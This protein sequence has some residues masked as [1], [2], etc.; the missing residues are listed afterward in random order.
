MKIRSLFQRGISLLLTLA[1]L[2]STMSGCVQ[3]TPTPSNPIDTE[4]T[5]PTIDTD[6]IAD[7]IIDDLVQDATDSIIYAQPLV[8]SNDWEDY[9]GDIETF[10][11]GLLTHQLEYNYEVFPAAVELSDGTDIY[12]LAYTD[13]SECYTDENEELTFFSAGI[14]TFCGERSIP[15]DEFEKGLII[16][17]LE[18]QDEQFGFLL[19]YVTDEFTEHCVVFDQYLKYGVNPSGQITYAVEKYE[20][21]KCDETLGSLYSYD[22]GKYLLFVVNAV[23]Y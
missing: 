21:G 5:N 20:K 11:Y 4:T 7:Q 13:Y 18:Y 2:M 9:V 15:Q 8:L 14:L 1:I 10:V 3:N 17:N 12:G 6:A 23:D 22:E 16:E 19:K